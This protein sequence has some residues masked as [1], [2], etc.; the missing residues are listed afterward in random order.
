MHKG[1]FNRNLHVLDVG[2]GKLKV[3]RKPPSTAPAMNNASLK[4]DNKPEVL[5]LTEDL[6]EVKKYLVE[7]IN[8][9]AEKVKKSVA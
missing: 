8:L 5:R 1:N 3:L 2:E 4:K 9:L 7:R 6:L